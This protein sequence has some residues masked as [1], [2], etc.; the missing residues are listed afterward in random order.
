MTFTFTTSARSVN[1]P[2]AWGA[3]QGGQ[4]W[5]TTNSLNGAS[6]ANGQETWLIQGEGGLLKASI[7]FLESLENQ[8][9]IH[10]TRT[11]C[12]ESNQLQDDKEFLDIKSN[13]TI[14]N[15]NVSPRV[16]GRIGW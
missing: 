10:A 8:Y 14:R 1:L 12:C 15:N 2:R 16:S 6:R 7:I 4:A 3:V 13:K 11:G 9:H 5:R